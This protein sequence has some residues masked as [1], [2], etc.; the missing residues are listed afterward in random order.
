MKFSFAAI[1]SFT[2][3]ALAA[4]ANPGFVAIPMSRAPTPQRESA[5]ASFAAGGGISIDMINT[6]MAYYVDLEVGGQKITVHVDTGSSDLWV[7]SS[8]STYCINDPTECHKTGTYDH[9][10]SKNSNNTGENFSIQYGIGKAS[11][12]YY[13]DDAAL[14]SA[15]VSGLQFGVSTGDQSSGKVS[16]FGIGYVNGEAT[17]NHYPNFPV[18]LKEQ[19]V[20]KH[21]VYSMAFGLPGDKEGSEITFGAYNTGKYSGSLKT[22]PVSTETHFG[23]RCDGAKIGNKTILAGEDLILDSGTSLTYLTKPNYNAV[24]DA[25][26]KS[27]QLY[28]AGQGLTAFP[29]ADVDKVSMEYTFS[30]KTIKVSGKDMSIPATNFDSGDTSGLCVFGITESFGDLADL[31]LMGDTFLRAMYTVY[32]LDSNQISIAQAAAGK[33]N[34]YVEVTGPISN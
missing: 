24:M 5:A 29:C 18:L 15:K 14:G 19:G 13:K 33:E 11:G 28:D 6:V 21:N 20:I 27:V 34:N 1:G 3:L 16:V 31:N 2:A 17:H 10:K 23:L 12:K 7:Y 25:V 8:N 32:D 9:T 22:V 30:G 4:P 26:G